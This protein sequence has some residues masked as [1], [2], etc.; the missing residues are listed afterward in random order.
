[1]CDENGDLVVID[2]NKVIMVTCKIRDKNMPEN[3]HVPDTLVG[4]HPDMVLKY[5]WTSQKHKDDARALMVED[6]AKPNSS[7]YF[8]S[9]LVKQHEFILTKIIEG[10][11]CRKLLKLWNDALIDKENKVVARP[12]DSYSFLI[13]L[14]LKNKEIERRC[15]CK[16][17]ENLR[18]H[19]DTCRVWEHP[20]MKR[21]SCRHPIRSLTT[22][23]LPGCGSHSHRD[24]NRS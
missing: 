4:R 3:K 10:A 15:D 7:E 16:A 8:I 5:S 9:R 1:L 19:L 18:G 6:A 13:L 2:G 12:T 24:P 11:V 21:C 17:A 23:H 14:K 22:H 20:T